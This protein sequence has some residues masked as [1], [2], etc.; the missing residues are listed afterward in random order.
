MDRGTGALHWSYDAGEDGGENF[1][2][3]MWL[4]DGVLFAGTDGTMGF[5]YAFDADSGA[6]RWRIEAGGEGFSTDVLHHEEVVLAVALDG[7]MERLV[8]V[9]KE[10]GESRWDFARPR[11]GSESATLNRSATIV[12]GAVY[13]GTLAGWV[14]ALD[15]S[16]GELLCGLTGE[17]VAFL[18]RSGAT[19]N[20]KSHRFRRWHTW[21]SSSKLAASMSHRPMATMPTRWTGKPMV[22]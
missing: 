2:G 15:A 18:N 22:G 12:E 20:M 14:Y 3:S 13:L 1:H 21:T 5:L 6:V 8:A 11:P 10:T 9:D 4:E 7:Q 16:S 17:P 19:L